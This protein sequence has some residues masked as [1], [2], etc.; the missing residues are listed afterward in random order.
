[1][2]YKGMPFSRRGKI[3]VLNNDVYNNTSFKLFLI[4]DTLKRNDV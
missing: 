4:A 1:M 2:L 3:R